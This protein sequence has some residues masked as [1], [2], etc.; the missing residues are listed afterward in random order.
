M[1]PLHGENR[2]LVAF[3]LQQM[4]Q[5]LR[6]GLGAI[7][8]AARIKNKKITAEEIAF[9]IA[10]RLN[11]AGRMG[12]A[13][14]AFDLLLAK[15]KEEACLLAQELQEENNRRQALEAKIFKEACTLVAEGPPENV[16]RSFLL[17]AHEEWH[18]GVL[19]IVASRMVERFSRPVMLIALEGGRGQGSGR[20]FGD[21]DLGRHLS[22]AARCCRDLVGIVRRPV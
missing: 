13:V 2:I 7:R 6:P 17:L 15:E 14:R 22:C 20:S 9:I 18:P 19:G 21:F 10:P 3:G 8:A 1:V 12:D 11:A 4:E 5:V 16:G